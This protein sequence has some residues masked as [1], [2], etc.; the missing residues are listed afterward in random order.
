MWGYSHRRHNSRDDRVAISVGG[1]TGKRPPRPPPTLVRAR[2]V[3]A[4]QAYTHAGIARRLRGCLG[5]LVGGGWRGR[6]EARANCRPRR[7]FSGGSSFP[8]PRCRNLEADNVAPQLAHAEAASGAT[9]AGGS[10][11]S[12]THFSRSEA[13]RA[14]VCLCVRVCVYLR[15]SIP[16]RLLACLHCACASAGIVCARSRIYSCTWRAGAWRWLRLVFFPVLRWYRACVF[17]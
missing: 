16:S 15:V 13:A 11:Y 12:A 14:C 1:P 6:N 9:S 4:G 3:H 17:D 10:L 5:F 2:S 7:G 8:P